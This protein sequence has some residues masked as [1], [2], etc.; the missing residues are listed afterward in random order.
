MNP[1]KTFA[2]AALLLSLLALPRTI[3]RA[4]HRLRLSGFFR[5]IQDRIYLPCHPQCQACQR[6][7]QDTYRRAPRGRI[8]EDHATAEFVA[9]KFRAAGLDTKIVPYRVLFNYPTVVKVEA[10]A[11][12]ASNS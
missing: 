2:S 3:L 8:P 11:P 7:A 10:Y 4:L 12:T 5:R 1:L 6:G 9:E